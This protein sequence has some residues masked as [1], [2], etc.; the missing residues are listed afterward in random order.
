MKKLVNMHKKKKKNNPFWVDTSHWFY[1]DDNVRSYVIN[2]IESNREN[3]V[4]RTA[5]LSD[6]WNP[7]EK[8]H[9]QR[10]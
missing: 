8:F 5:M 1:G 2:S 10:V 3:S 6:I 4:L 9:F 7:T